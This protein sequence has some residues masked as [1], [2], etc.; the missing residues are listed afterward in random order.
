M[1]I[2]LTV[3]VYVAPYAVCGVV[4]AYLELKFGSKV[5]AELAAELTAIKAR[6]SAAE[7]AV[8]AKV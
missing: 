1:D 7:A 2:L 8:K 6:L 5:T 4:G 3:L